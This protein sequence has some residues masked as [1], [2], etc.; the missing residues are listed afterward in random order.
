MADL[1]TLETR[2][3]T[4]LDDPAGQRYSSTVVT[5]A[6]SHA[7]TELNLRQPRLIESEFTVAIPGRDQPLAGLNK[8]FYLLHLVRL[9]ESSSQML[10]PE[11][12]FTYQLVNGIPVLHFRTEHIPQTGEQY[13]VCYASA[14]TLAGLEGASLTT[15]PAELEN[16]LVEGA[17]GQACALRAGSLLEAYGSRGEECAALLTLADYWHSIFLRS[18]AG[19]RVIQEFGFPPGFI[20]DQWDGRQVA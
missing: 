2:L 3:R 15:L 6:F 9:D 10:E 16:A 4:L 18:L 20:L 7:L 11:T 1:T 14:H 12:C 17:A 19:A 13:K 5:A 8:C